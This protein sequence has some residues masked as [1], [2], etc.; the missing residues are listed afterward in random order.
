MRT[1]PS[2]RRDRILAAVEIPA[3]GIWLG[4]LTGFAFASAPI[5]FRLIAP[6]DVVRFAALT[7]G[8]LTV[9][10]RWGYTLGTIAL[11]AALLR[12]AGASD[13]V[14]DVARAALIV[15]AL[16]LTFYHQHVIVRAMLGTEIGSPAYHAL[17]TRS[18]LIY[19]AALVALLAA[20]VVAA[21]RRE[22]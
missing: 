13:R 1:T 16:A 6:L 21:V 20:L 15:L 4:A 7:Q 5:A 10:T 14:A 12:A 2:A 11:I 18:S 3:L 22:S 9:L 17:H 19:G 8:T